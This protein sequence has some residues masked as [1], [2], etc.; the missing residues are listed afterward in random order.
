MTRS[1]CRTASVKRALKSSRLAYSSVRPY[2]GMGKSR[3]AAYH[4]TSRS[5][6]STVCPRA[7]SSRMSPRY[8]VACPLPHEEVME[9]PMITMSSTA[10]LTAAP[11]RAPREPARERPRPVR[12]GAHRYALLTRASAPPDR[13]VAPAQGPVPADGRSPRRH[14][15]PRGIRARAQETTQDLISPP[16]VRER[17]LHAGFVGCRIDNAAGIL[18]V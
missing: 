11:P 6:K 3:A 9:S 7:T 4:G 17:L 2:G 18:R 14:Y 5:R 10:P 1:A 16:S 12:R 15:G 8:V 13:Y